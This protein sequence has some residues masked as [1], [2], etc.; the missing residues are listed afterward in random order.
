MLRREGW[1]VN[2][3]RVER[4]YREEKLSLR[5]KHRKKRPARL[6][7]VLDKATRVNQHWSMDF[8]HDTLHAG[9]RFRV[10]TMV[11]DCSREGLAT[12]AD[13]SINGERVTKILDRIVE[14]RGKPEVI[15]C[16]NGPEFAGQKLDRWAY[17][18]GVKLHFITPG[19]PVENAYCESFN[20]RL[21]DECLNEN[22]FLTLDEAR[23]K[24]EHWRQDYNE[25]RP[26]GSLNDM[27][28]VEFASK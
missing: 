9:R 19:K 16:D 22:H 6:R 25:V 18:N 4:I 2:H 5:L 14:R 11:D 13:I 17:N 23:T 10:F 15:I 24:L 27:T 20:G 1:K 7:L 28:P 3:K 12:Y 21:R 26:H 8:V